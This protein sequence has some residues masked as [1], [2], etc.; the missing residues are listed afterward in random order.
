[1]F[2]CLNRHEQPSSH[3]RP[4]QP[5]TGRAF[6][7]LNRHE[8][9]SSR[10]D[11]D[12]IPAR[13]DGFNAS[14]GTSNLQARPRAARRRGWQEFQCL[15]RHEQPSSQTLTTIGNA[16]AGFN[17]SIGTSNLQ[18]ARYGGPAG[19]RRDV[20]MPQSARATFKLGQKIGQISLNLFVSMPQSARATFKLGPPPVGPPPRRR[21]NA[22]IGTSN[23]QAPPLTG[24]RAAT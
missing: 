16:L 20:S 15:N 11:N 12:R 24:D 4:T 22:S 13:W 9:P 23:L 8:Q 7:C 14:I 18:A 5:G 1:M 6:Q 19:D 2:Q 21:F 10:G 17:A 3:A